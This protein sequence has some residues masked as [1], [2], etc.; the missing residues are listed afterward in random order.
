MTDWR[1]KRKEREK[2]GSGRKNVRFGVRLLETIALVA[3]DA[4]KT[5]LIAWVKRHRDILKNYNLVATAH[6]G[7]LVQEEGLPVHCF[8]PGPLGGDQEVGAQIVQGHIDLLV[9]FRDP[10]TVQP[11]EPDINAVLRVC[12]VH[13]V[14]VATNEATADVLIQKFARECGA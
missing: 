8:N 4:K 5:A 14:L 3:H 9:F 7:H 12:D 1:M 10:L 13:N 6:T 11:H 2:I